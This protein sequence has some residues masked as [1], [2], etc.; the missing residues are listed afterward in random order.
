MHAIIVT[1]IVFWA[2][3]VISAHHQRTAAQRRLKRSR[4]DVLIALGNVPHTE[5]QEARRQALLAL[6][7]GAPRRYPWRLVIVTSVVVAIGVVTLTGRATVT[8]VPVDHA[9]VNHVRDVD[10]PTKAPR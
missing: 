7:G 5:G 1:F 4:I 8:N 2:L 10:F 3:S 6:C 9:A